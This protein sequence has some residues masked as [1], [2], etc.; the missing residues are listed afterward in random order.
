[1]FAPTGGFRGWQIQWNHTKCCGADP[2]CDGNDIWARSGVQSPTSLLFIIVV[3]VVTVL[4]D[5]L[6]ISYYTAPYFRIYIFKTNNGAVINKNVIK[7]QIHLNVTKYNNLL[8]SV[9]YKFSSILSYSI[10]FC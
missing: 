4:F 9:L 2:C 10:S 3:F 6:I 8:F 1:M 5:C 7:Q